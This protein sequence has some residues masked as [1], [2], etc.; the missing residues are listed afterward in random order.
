[1]SLKHIEKIN[2]LKII[3]T[4]W[5][6]SKYGVTSGPYLDTFHAVH[7]SHTGEAFIIPLIFWSF[8]AVWKGKIGLK[9]INWFFIVMH[10]PNSRFLMGAWSFWEVKQLKVS[11]FEPL[12]S[13]MIIFLLD[14]Y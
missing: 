5:K 7:I 1:M 10:E 12:Q 14:I 2:N 9:R 3:Y 13:S 4:A 6:D 11:I 8:Q